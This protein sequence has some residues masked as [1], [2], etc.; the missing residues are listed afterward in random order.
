MTL[1]ILYHNGSEELIENSD[2]R[3]VAA[4][5][6]KALFVMPNSYPE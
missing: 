4:P 5:Y 6:H 3:N 1:L 2:M